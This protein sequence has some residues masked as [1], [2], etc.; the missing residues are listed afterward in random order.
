MT[1][2]TDRLG[3]ASLRTFTEK[4]DHLWLEQNPAKNKCAEL[5]RAGH[6][7][8]WVSPTPAAPNTGRLLL[9]STIYTSEATKQ[10]LKT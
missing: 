9:D 8:A 5:A 1:T 7:V 4:H 10:F 2:W 3:T 6:A